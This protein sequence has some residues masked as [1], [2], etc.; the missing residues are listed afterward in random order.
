MK[1]QGRESSRLEFKEQLPKSGQII[2]TIIAFCNMHGG[3]LVVG[4]SDSSEIIGLS[5]KGAHEAMEWLNE[6]IYSSCAPPILPQI[7]QQNIDGKY[8]VVIDV[9]SGMQKPYYKKSW[10]YEYLSG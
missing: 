5:E 2:N 6:S 1:F 7:Y 4:V 3:K 8:L 9:S 10:P